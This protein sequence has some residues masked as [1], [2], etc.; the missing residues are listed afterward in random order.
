MEGLADL[1][2]HGSTLLE[3]MGAGALGS[4]Q[5][6]AKGPTCDPRCQVLFLRWHQ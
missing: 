4:T 6:Q 1:Q 2:G 5:C 3:K